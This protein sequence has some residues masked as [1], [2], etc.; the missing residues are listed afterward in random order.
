[1]FDLSYWVKRSWRKE[2]VEGGRKGEKETAS[3]DMSSDLMKVN[4]PEV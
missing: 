1:V 2:T 4:H 3:P